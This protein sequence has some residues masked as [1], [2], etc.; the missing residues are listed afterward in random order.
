MAGDAEGVGA[1]ERRVAELERA[2]AEAR[3]ENEQM[4]VLLE[5]V[6]VGVYQTDAAGNNL[7]VNPRWCEMTGLTPAQ[8]Q[9]DSWSEAI[10]PEDRAGVFAHWKH[11][12][13][14]G[15]EFRFESR[16]LRPDGTSIW[17]LAQAVPVRAPDGTI[18]GYVGTATDITERYRMAE[19]ER[20]QDA[21]ERKVQ[22]NAAELAAVNKEL[23][24][25]EALIE[26]TADAI[27]VTSPEGE[28]LHANPSF[29][30]R[31]GDDRGV[32][33]RA[34]D[35]VI[36][37]DAET[38]QRIHDSFDAAERFQ[39]TVTLQGTAGAFP[40]EI[41]GFAIRAE[42]GL[43]GV[44][45]VIRDLTALRQAEDE[46]A[47]LQAQVIESQEVII[48][49]M[50]TPLLPL[51]DHV[52]AM[53]LVGAI[54]NARAQQI[55][56]TLLEGIG[57]HEAE[58]AILDVTGVRTVD[59]QVAD[60]LLRASQAARLL[61]ADVVLTGISPDMAGIFIELG[62]D[63]RGTKTLSTLQSAIE[64]ALGRRARPAPAAARSK[65][66]TR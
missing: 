34:L 20:A 15:K 49:E 24:L 9:G 28:I 41:D 40:A 35:E 44:A 25:F 22:E 4:R 50:S 53:P 37:L 8:S 2:L 11:C 39:G 5:M 6:P 13:E 63:I 27:A 43:V 51:A 17:H 31:F 10:H 65:S 64:F 47:A 12:V 33:G 56:E 36:N 52:I 19:T 3:R 58:I 66:S 55:L 23:R 59:A 60:A 38:L 45:I 62:I 18:N 21:L 32:V 46:R 61:G 48:R 54:G 57:H 1:A 26:N 42:A 29:L 14:T 7:Y 16:M 30:A